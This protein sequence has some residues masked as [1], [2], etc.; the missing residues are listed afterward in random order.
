MTSLMT[1][2]AIFKLDY[3]CFLFISKI[4]CIYHRTISYNMVAYSDSITQ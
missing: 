1:L 3:G 4:Y 2:Y